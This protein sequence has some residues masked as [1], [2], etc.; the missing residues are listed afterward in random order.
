MSFERR[1]S[2]TE[3]HH[4]LK[5][6]GLPLNHLGLTWKF[7]D[8]LGNEEMMVFPPV[9]ADDLADEANT[10]FPGFVDVA[11]TQGPPAQKLLPIQTE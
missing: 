5:C 8:A 6:S 4:S 7:W 1:Q 3:N 10:A 11:P 9:L 2:S